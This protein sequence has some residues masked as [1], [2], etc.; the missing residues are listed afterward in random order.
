M[1]CDFYFW[2]HPKLALNQLGFALLAGPKYYYDCNYTI[3][4]RKAEP[5]CATEHKPAACS[6]KES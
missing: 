6:C 3:R 2:K 4:G 1:F 5:V